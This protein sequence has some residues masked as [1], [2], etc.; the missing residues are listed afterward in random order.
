MEVK[1]KK[2][3][4][5][6]NS[7][8][9][10]RR[11]SI[12]ELP[13]YCNELRQFIVSQV[14]INP[15]HLG[16]S[17]GALEI[18]VAIHYV[19][20]TPNDRLIWDVG[21]QAYAHK[22][23][24]GRRDVFNTNRR[25]GG[26]SGFPR[27]SESPYDAFGVGHASTSI[28]AAVGMAAAS[29]IKG[30]NRKVIAVIGDGSMSGGLAFEGL[31]NVGD[32]DVLVILNDNNIS[33][34]PNVGA[35][36]ESL[37]SLTTS[38]GY[39]RF[40]NRVWRALGF[41]PFMRRTIQKIEHGAKSF[42]L[43]HSNLFEA[44]KFRYFGPIDGNDV[45][46]LVKR[47]QDLRD[48]PGP[49]LLHALTVK[50]KGYAVAEARQTEW[51][52]P[53]L[54]DSATGIKTDKRSNT[55]RF[56]EV[57]GY[58][59]LALAHD[60]DKIV[61][62]TPAMPSGSSL[63]LMMNEMPDRA[64]DVGIA[65][66]HAVTF[67]AGLAAEG[68]MPFCNIYSSFAQRSIDNIIHD[69]ALQKLEVVFCLDRAGLVGEDGAT[70][71][72]VF[73][74]ALLRSIPNVIIAAPSSG[75]ELR[76]LMYTASLGGYGACFVI[77][78]PRGGAFDK[79]VLDLPFEKIEIGLSRLVSQGSAE[80]KV[81]ILSLGSTFDL[82]VMAAKELS[83]THYDLRFAK[84]LDNRMLLSLPD[85]YSRIIVL[86]DGV[87]H[88]GVASAIAE[89]YGEQCIDIQVCS[90]GIEDQFIEHGP[91][92]TLWHEAGLTVDHIL[93]VARASEQGTDR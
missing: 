22:I 82:A 60:N 80:S 64:F 68:L 33:I 81:V 59:I 18:A 17:L 72:G 42:F 29:H 91:L 6:V 50:G 8:E 11:L 90:I 58:T 79:S 49:K 63:N 31:N 38:K 10:L 12:D 75:L 5:L 27:R 88:G 89:F 84:P 9:D 93:A 62:I 14:S 32:H 54:F 85:R 36:K 35:L 28:S 78:Y 56:Q 57:F 70:H 23:I 41:W 3:L 40:K 53:G 76:Q 65:E 45:V 66:G 47:L 74:I 48:I 26:I 51:H 61:G 44:L 46:S 19:Y 15:G 86:E 1:N 7:P 37:L 13:L 52:A 34:D 73:D 43:H 2:Y 83:A 55:L 20:N 16:S 71:H 24:T 30:E 77:R 39:N 67:S 21:H 92:S 25:Y 69:V 4:E 87:R